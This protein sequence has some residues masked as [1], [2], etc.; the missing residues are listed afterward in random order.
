MDKFVN[1]ITLNAKVN[2]SVDHQNATMIVANTVSVSKTHIHA[3]PNVV[4]GKSFFIHLILKI[5]RHNFF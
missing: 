3:N 5:K 1:L 2:A 4:S